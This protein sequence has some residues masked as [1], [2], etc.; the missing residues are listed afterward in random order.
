MTKMS[1]ESMRQNLKSAL[2]CVQDLTDDVDEL[3]ITVE[4]RQ[5]K[6]EY[7]EQRRNTGCG[8]SCSNNSFAL[9]RKKNVSLNTNIY[10][11]G[12]ML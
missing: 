3:L 7:M 10:E 2:K 9:L 8:F 4:E 11:V 12:T 5:D 1:F 6:L